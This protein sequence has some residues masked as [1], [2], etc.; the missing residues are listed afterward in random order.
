MK[1]AEPYAQEIFAAALQMIAPAERR[2]CLIG[3]YKLL[4]QIG[5]GG[6]GVVWMPPKSP[7]GTNVLERL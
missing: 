7:Q 2:R 1:P 4:G 5:E 3:R 6:F